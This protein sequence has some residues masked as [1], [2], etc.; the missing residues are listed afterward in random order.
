MRNSHVTV[1]LRDE[2][3]LDCSY[4]IVRKG[5]LSVLVIVRNLDCAI[6]DLSALQKGGCRYLLL[7]HYP[8]ESIAYHDFLKLIGKMCTKKEDSKYFG[9]HLEEDNWMIVDEGDCEHMIHAGERVRF[10][11]RK[12]EFTAFIT[13]HAADFQ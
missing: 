7:K 12:R 5:P 2:N 6:Y 1:S 3:A 9:P 13:A 10:E 8:A 4:A 11:A